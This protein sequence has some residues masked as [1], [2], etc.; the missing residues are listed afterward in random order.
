MW[1][2]QSVQPNYVHAYS[3]YEIYP[4]PDQSSVLQDY[5]TL[6]QSHQDLVE[7]NSKLSQQITHLRCLT[8]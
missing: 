2:N 5:L 1:Y 8:E 7:E 4:Q 6:R 3:A